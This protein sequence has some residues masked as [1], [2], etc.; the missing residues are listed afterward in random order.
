[1][2]KDVIK[3]LKK[4]YPN[5]KYYL[6]FSSPIELMVAAILSAQVRD[7]IVNATTPHIFKKYKTA[8]DYAEADLKDL[9]AL[10]KSIPFYKNKCKNIKEACKILAEKHNSTVPR[11]MD[12]LTELPGIGR[13]TANAILINAFDIVNGIVVDTH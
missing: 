4:E 8:K 13:K 5:T 12:E 3:I 7:V 9:E 2:Q 1:M 11:T 10:V 6:N